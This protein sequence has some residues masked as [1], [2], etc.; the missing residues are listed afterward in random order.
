M[1]KS[2]ISIIIPVYNRHEI[3]WRVLDSVIK[4]TYRPIEVIV[5]DDGSKNRVQSSSK[6]FIS[7]QV[8]CEVQE[9]ASIIF[10]R[11]ENK[12]APAARNQG[13][14]ESRGEFVIFWDADI[15]AEPKVLASLCQALD[16]HPEISYAYCDYYFGKKKMSAGE[17]DIDKLKRLNYITTTSLIR[18]NDF[19]GWDESLKKFQD[20][21]VWLT[22]L[23]QNKIGVYVPDICLRV[24]STE[25]TYSQWLPSF[26]YRAPWRW[27]PGVRERA[28]AYELAKA[29]IKAKHSI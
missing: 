16:K 6:N 28:R 11:Q 21:D 22:M 25:G 27:L 14:R 26:A 24:I 9:K 13:F 10:L 2:L 29:V 15:M 7:R 8:E 17:F 20:W 3:F 18:R 23:D 1:S 19:P 4:Q 12:G 5:V